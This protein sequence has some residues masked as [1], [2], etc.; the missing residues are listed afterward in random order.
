M[1][2]HGPD[3]RLVDAVT[4]M[5][6]CEAGFAY[7]RNC[8]YCALKLNEAQVEKMSQGELR[9]SLRWYSAAQ[10]SGQKRVGFDVPLKALAAGAGK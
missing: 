10:K 8:R 7:D 6:H 5:Q 4:H 2:N 3:I 9:S 1:P